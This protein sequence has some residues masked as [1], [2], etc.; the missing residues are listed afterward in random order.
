M[1]TSEHYLITYNIFND[2]N[3]LIIEILFIILKC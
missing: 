1:Y 2:F 3:I